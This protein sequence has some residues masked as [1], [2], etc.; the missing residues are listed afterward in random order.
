MEGEAK[1]G[2]KVFSP[3]DVGIIGGA[4]FNIHMTDNAALV[5]DAGYYKGF[6]DADQRMSGDLNRNR[7][8][9]ANVGVMFKIMDNQDR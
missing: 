3:F 6:T 2:R 7:Y 8:W 4:G 1:D 5:L 9:T